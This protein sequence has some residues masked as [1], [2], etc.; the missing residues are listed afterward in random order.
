MLFTYIIIIG[1]QNMTAVNHLIQYNKVIYEFP[2]CQ[3]EF[4]TYL[5]ILVLSEGRCLFDVC[6]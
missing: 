4:D 3:K 5:S 2:Y 6:K 1:I